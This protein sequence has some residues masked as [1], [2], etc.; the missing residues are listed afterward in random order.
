MV[1]VEVNRRHSLTQYSKEFLRD[2]ATAQLIEAEKY[3]RLHGLKSKK[4]LAVARKETPGKWPVVTWHSLQRRLKGEVRTG[5]ENAGNK[6]LTNRER[7]EL[8]AAMSAAGKQGQAFDTD[9]RNQ[10]VVDILLHRDKVNKKG[11]RTFIKLSPHARRTLRTGKPGKDFW[12][13]FFIKHR[14]VVCIMK[15]K[16]TSIM[17]LKQC[18]YAVAEKHIRDLTALLIAKDIYD[19]EEDCIYEGKEGNIIW[20]DEM[21]QFGIL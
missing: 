4:G 15:E 1:L 20:Q 6:M 2:D 9:E 7:R 13:S 5:D 19:P 3:C 21:G 12:K 11:G 18:T 16:V 17:Q 10:A 14:D 8:A